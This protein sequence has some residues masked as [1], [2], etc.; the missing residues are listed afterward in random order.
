MFILNVA[1]QA[2]V[3]QFEQSLEESCETILDRFTTLNQS[4]RLEHP[5]ISTFSLLQPNTQR[6]LVTLL[7]NSRSGAYFRRLE[8]SP[9]CLTSV[10]LVE[11]LDFKTVKS[12]QILKSLVSFAESGLCSWADAKNLILTQQGTR[13]NNPKPKRYTLDLIPL[14]IRAAHSAAQE[15]ATVSIENPPPDRENNTSL[16]APE[17]VSSSLT[18]SRSLASSTYDMA[19]TPSQSSRSSKISSASV[20]TRRPSQCTSPSDS[21]T[22]IFTGYSPQ[23]TSPSS[24]GIS[25]ETTLSTAKSSGRKRKAKEPAVSS[26]TPIKVPRLQESA[27]PE[28]E[29]PPGN[30]EQSPFPADELP[31]RIGKQ[32]SGEVAD[33]C[34]QLRD[35]EWLTGSTIH[36]LCRYFTKGPIKM[37]QVEDAGWEKNVSS[38]PRS[39][40]RWL[41][42]RWYNG[43]FNLIAPVCTNSHWSMFALDHE[44]K[45]V[46]HLD[47]LAKPGED[48]TII[49]AFHDFVKHVTNLDDTSEWR[50]EQLQVPQQTDDCNC[51]LYL[52]M[53]ALSFAANGRAPET[54][55]PSTLRT[56]FASLLADNFSSLSSCILDHVARDTDSVSDET[57][58]RI[59]QFH[60]KNR[61][62][63]LIEAYIDT[64]E[65]M[66]LN[67]MALIIHT[68]QYLKA[69]HRASTQIAARIKARST[70]LQVIEEEHAEPQAQWLDFDTGPIEE[71]SIRNAL[72][73]YQRA[74]NQVVK[75]I[76]SAEK[77]NQFL[78]LA[79][80]HLQ[81]TLSDLEAARSELVSEINGEVA[82]M[83][84]DIA[85][86]QACISKRSLV[87]IP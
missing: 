11:A 76:G 53:F 9:W 29:A 26:E 13:L 42:P 86:L 85:M 41:P 28:N 27:V 38:H 58:A 12:E 62:A 8:R 1:Q 44:K 61:S 52:V 75:E 7:S 21:E 66:H 46:L 17:T 4:L 30:S 22:S 87:E 80:K 81:R 49:A 39:Q 36:L 32:T 35:N 77:Q 84:C 78:V 18:S 64:L 14:D 33:A 15:A 34:Q 6:A 72:E 74:R 54:F 2:R 51:G 55:D 63:S 50:L 71:E 43:H 68:R 37:R 57:P 83:Q 16:N 19:P 25:P 5:G 60:P 73:E 45:V 70:R 10:Q 56:V 69:A 67:F 59:A 82:A 48:S 79:L 24:F 3:R 31:S 23:L 40:I 20:S 47:S 65:T